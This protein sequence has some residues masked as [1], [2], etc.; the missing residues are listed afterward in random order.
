MTHPFHAHRE[1]KKSYERVGKILKDE[2]SGSKQHADKGAFDRSSTK[3]A[4]ESHDYRT[5]GKKAPGRYARGGRAIGGEATPEN[6]AKWSARA[7][8]NSYARGGALPTAGAATGVGR[9]QKADK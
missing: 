4:A 6:L 8:S 5:P 7:A 3:S 2:P 9:L 1:T